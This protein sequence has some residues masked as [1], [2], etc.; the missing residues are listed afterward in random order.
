MDLPDFAGQLGKGMA[1]IAA[2]V[3]PKHFKIPGLDLASAPTFAPP[4]SL[5]APSD[6]GGGGGGLQ[7]RGGGGSYPV[8][9]PSGGFLQLPQHWSG[10]HVTSGLGWGAKTAE[11]IMGH[12]GTKVGAPESGTVM[13][14]HPTGAQGGGS[15][16]FKADSGRTYWLGHLANGVPGGTR[17]RAG[18][19]LALISADH[20]APHVHIDA[21]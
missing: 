9:K 13:Y 16:M 7:A 1:G 17:L 15:M 11:D 6:G 2:P 14:W 20:A 19:V 5:S 12:A 3:Q 4:P 10:T 21:R 18:Q 8:T